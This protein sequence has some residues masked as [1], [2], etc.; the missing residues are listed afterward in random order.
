MV[1]LDEGS[2]MG[3]EP[4]DFEDTEQAIMDSSGK[5]YRDM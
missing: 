1:G 2:E 3:E 4:G 5:R